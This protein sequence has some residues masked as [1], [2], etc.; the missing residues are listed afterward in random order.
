MPAKHGV[1]EF[2][3]IFQDVTT[4]FF[5]LERDL[6]VV[7]DEVGNIY[8]V[9]PAFEKQLGRTEAQSLHYEMIRLV[10]EDDLAAFI[11]SF[12]ATTKPQP[13][14]LLKREHGE[15]VVKLIAFKFTRVEEGLRGFLVLRPVA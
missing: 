1:T 8:R 9:N 10:H 5:D 13:I 11:R 2:L 7:L 14:R 4:T 12:D 3:S 15:I 6:L